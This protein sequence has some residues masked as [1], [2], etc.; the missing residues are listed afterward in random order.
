RKY[1]YF[2]GVSS[3]KGP[4]WTSI[5]PDRLIKVDLRNKTN[6][7]WSEK[8]KIPNE[9]IFVA[10]PSSKWTDEDDGVILS[11]LINKKDDRVATLLILNAKDMQELAR[12]EFKTTGPF[13]SSLHG[14][15]ANHADKIHLLT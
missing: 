3:D 13:T 1:N 10:N 7:H 9:P 6:K 14:Q 12:V 5:V 11:T 2:Y 8:G 4:N 15:W